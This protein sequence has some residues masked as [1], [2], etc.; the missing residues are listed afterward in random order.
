MQILSKK[1]DELNLEYCFYSGTFNR[2][3]FK[4]LI[5]QV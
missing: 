3:K 2:Y 4:I 5:V 1:L